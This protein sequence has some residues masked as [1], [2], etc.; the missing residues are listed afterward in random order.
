MGND[1]GDAASR[2]ATDEKARRREPAGYLIDRSGGSFFI[3]L[4]E[5]NN[6]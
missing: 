2:R 6:R 3:A 5:L 1:F 4:P